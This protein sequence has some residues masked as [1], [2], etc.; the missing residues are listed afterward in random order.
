MKNMKQRLPETVDFIRSR[1][2]NTPYIG[3]LT[4]TGL[5]E[6]AESMAIETTIN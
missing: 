6:S 4:G 1:I 3:L 5:G 2:K